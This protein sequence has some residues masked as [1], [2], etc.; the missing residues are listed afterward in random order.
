MS[1]TPTIHRD[2]T[3][4][5]ITTAAAPAPPRPTNADL[6]ARDPAA[7][8]EREAAFDDAFEFQGRTLLPFSSSR[9][10]LWLQHRVAMGAPN[11]DATLKDLDAF[12]ADA[13]RI[14]FLC[15]F[16]PDQPVNDRTPSWT[17]LRA[18]AWALQ[19]AIDAWGESLHLEGTEHE[20]T[21]LAYR[22]YA[23]SLVNRHTV[24]PAAPGASSDDLGN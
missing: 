21:V 20:A 9:K 15:S 17:R 1:D 2:R 22:I 8:A 3:E 13:L 4:P 14:L 18:D 19:A 12:Y 23:S 24:A 5:A 11:L 6:L 7:E 16:Q 10:S